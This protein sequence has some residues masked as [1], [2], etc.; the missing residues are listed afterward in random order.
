MYIFNSP[1]WAMPVVVF[2]LL[3]ITSYLP[4]LAAFGETLPVP[5]VLASYIDAKSHPMT[6]DGSTA[7]WSADLMEH[8]VLFYK[9][10]GR[11]GSPTSLGTTVCGT[12]D[13]RKDGEVRFCLAHDGEDLYIL[14]IIRDDLLEQ[15]TSENNANEAWK[16]DGLHIYIDSTHARRK[17]IPDPPLKNQPGYE[18]F[19]VST[20]YN[21][22]TEGCDFVTHL[23]ENGSAAAGAQPD[24]MNWLVKTRITGTGPYTYVFEQR[25]PLREVPGHNLKTM[26][27]GETYGIN[28][29]F[30][31]S[32]A[33]KFLEGYVFWSSD[34]KTDAY[35]DQNLWG[36]MTLEPVRKIPV[37]AGIPAKSAIPRTHGRG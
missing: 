25:I 10:D 11:P 37:H 19:G 24:Q 34:G 1:R 36:E 7:D 20:D 3:V 35:I 22:Y 28:V 33:G 32:D 13:D 2:I 8:S 14:T 17:G 31:D 15:R 30:V 26:C 21:C 29:E 27:P 12:M 16:E 4:S 23:G 9:G 6:I 18:Q 5:Q